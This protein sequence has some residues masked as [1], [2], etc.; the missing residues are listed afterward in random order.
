MPSGR[1]SSSSSHSG[2][3]SGGRGE[4]SLRV[5]VIT[6]LQ[7]SSFCTVPDQEPEHSPPTAVSCPTHTPDRLLGGTK[8]MENIQDCTQKRR[9]DL[10]MHWEHRNPGASLQICSEMHKRKLVFTY[11]NPQPQPENHGWSIS[12]SGTCD[13]QTPESMFPLTLYLSNKLI[14]S[15]F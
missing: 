9:Q 1:T 14:K 12:D 8:R 11:L 10:C 6:I 15:P 13:A 5:V 4:P 7:N 2:T 3:D